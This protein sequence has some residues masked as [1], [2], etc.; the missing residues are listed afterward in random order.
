MNLKSKNLILLNLLYCYIP[1]MLFLLGWVKIWIAIP[2]C[3]GLF[4][5]LYKFF[6][7]TENNDIMTLNRIV[8]TSGLFIFFAICLSAGMG[9][10]WPQVF[11]YEKHNAVLQDLVRFDWPVIY[12]KYDKALLT[13]YIGHYLPPALVGKI[14]GSV[15]FGDYLMG[16]WGYL[17]VILVSI[18]VMVLVQ[19]K[20]WKKQ[21]LTLV[22]FLLFS[23]MLYPLQ[24][25]LNIFFSDVLV[26][27]NSDVSSLGCLSTL[28]IDGLHLEYRSIFT[29]IQ[30]AHQQSIIPWLCCSTLMM[31]KNNYSNYALLVLPAFISGTWSFL[32]I[33]FIA[34]VLILGKLIHSQENVWKQIF[35][36]SNIFCIFIPGFIFF[37]YFIGNM[38]VGNTT[39]NGS[40]FALDLSVQHLI[41]KILFALFM[42]GLYAILIGKYYRK[43]LLFWAICIEL[44]VI[45]M[46]SGG[47]F[48]MCTSIP[49]LFILYVLIIRYLFT[50]FLQERVRK[51]ILIVCL[52]IGARNPLI[53]IRKAAI[54]DP[55]DHFKEESLLECTNLDNPEIGNAMK[56]Q[57]YTYNP[58]NT[59]FYKYIMRK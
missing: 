20:N 5:F 14:F 51:I 56:Y 19:A 40:E 16:L 9:N 32:G 35:S 59:I 43:D 44:T 38:I 45:P 13:Y 4:Y 58:D 6:V 29:D 12:D 36:G 49:S 2:A 30:W 34:F 25:I 33:V 3:L 17:G 39:S 24:Y 37:F 46:F 42:F 23:G 22:G 21:L 31:Q 8:I 18:N 57:Y 7:N 53:Q 11:D 26:Y 27:P 55:Y 50:D 48:V 28:Y 41:Y 47:D 10:W 1:L 15:R 54:H 52:I